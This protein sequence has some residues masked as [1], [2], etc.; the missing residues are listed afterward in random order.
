[1]TS[2]KV[3]DIKIKVLDDD[4]VVPL[5]DF[6]AGKIGLIDFWHTKCVKCPAALAKLNDEAERNQ[7]AVYIACALSLGE[8]SEDDVKDFTTE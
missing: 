4:R 2:S 8:G 7:D 5:K 3:P 1:M 6:C